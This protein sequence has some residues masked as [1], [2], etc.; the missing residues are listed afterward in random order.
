VVINSPSRNTI[1]TVLHPN[2]NKFSSFHDHAGPPI[3]HMALQHALECMVNYIVPRCLSPSNNLS[4]VHEFTNVISLRKQNNIETNALLQSL[5]TKQENSANMS[6]V[7]FG[8][9]NRF[10]RSATGM[11]HFIG[12]GSGFHWGMVI[13]FFL[14]CNQLH[15]L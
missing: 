10:I 6:L 2:N 14:S 11:V 9:C 7:A 1:S 13:F 12:F 15:D 4:R 3:P 5:V 8:R